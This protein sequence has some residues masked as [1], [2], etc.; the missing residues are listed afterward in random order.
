MT[1][2]SSSTSGATSEAYVDAAGLRVAA[3]LHALVTD[4]I[5]ADAG[6]DAAAFW[7]GLADAVVE[8]GAQNRALLERRDELQSMIDAWLREDPA[9]VADA[10]AQEAFLRD[11]CYLVAEPDDAPITPARPT[12]L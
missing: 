1:A 6:V 12:A 11:I 7:Q 5:L 9:R 2:D 10:D 3:P 8:L 4:T